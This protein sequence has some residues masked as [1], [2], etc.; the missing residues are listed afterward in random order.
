MAGL[1]PR[2]LLD[3]DEDEFEALMRAVTAKRRED[4]WTQSTEILAHIYET[5]AAILAR[6]DAGIATVAAK[7]TRQIR[8]VEPYP[9][10]EWVR[11]DEGS[12]DGDDVVVVRSMRDA[13]SVLQN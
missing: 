7:E 8:P 13:L 3:Y 12:G 4:A 10:P 1:E 6:L 5:L 2:V 9:R 11:E